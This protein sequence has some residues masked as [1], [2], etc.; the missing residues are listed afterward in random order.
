MWNKMLKKITAVVM[1]AAVAVTAGV[2][3]GAVRTVAEEAEEQ[4]G[5]LSLALAD[6]DADVPE[7]AAE[8]APEAQEAQEAEAPARQ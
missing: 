6:P 3:P 7:E 8:A 5:Q 1:A 2:L 4:E